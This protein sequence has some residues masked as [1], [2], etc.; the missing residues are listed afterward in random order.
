MIIIKVCNATA[1]WRVE[2][3]WWCPGDH[4]RS[5]QGK[6]VENDKPSGRGVGWGDKFGSLC[7]PR[8]PSLPWKAPRVCCMT[9]ADGVSG[10]FNERPSSH[11]DISKL[12]RELNARFFQGRWYGRRLQPGD[13]SNTL[14]WPWSRGSFLLHISI[15]WQ[16]VQ[17]LTKEKGYLS[18]K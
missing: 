11:C 18:T 5:S 8:W 3:Q 10:L 1:A 13:K 6:S 9:W 14:Q 12:V 17:S 7:I 16:T 2:K 15:W 4:Q